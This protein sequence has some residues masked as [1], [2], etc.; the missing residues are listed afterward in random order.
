[1]AI[2]IIAAALTFSYVTWRDWSG[3][4]PDSDLRGWRRLATLTA[5][6]SILAS[7]VLFVS[8]AA[9]NATGNRYPYGN[10]VTLRCIPVGN[11]LSLASMLLGI[12]GKGKGRWLTLA[13]GGLMLILWLDQG[14][15][16]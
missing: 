10:S 12:A 7:A 15:S 1:M 3:R 6:L 16:L 2:L 8:Y 14:M 11:Y 13:S 9:L 4:R 5:I